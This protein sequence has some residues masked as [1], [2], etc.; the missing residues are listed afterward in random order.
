MDQ[1]SAAC[2]GTL[3][4]T[5]ASVEAGAARTKAKCPEC[6]RVAVIRQSDFPHKNS[7]DNDTNGE[8]GNEP[9]RSH[10]ASM[11]TAHLTTSRL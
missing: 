10:A 8:Q 9:P 2:P 7:K 5:Y 6:A 4:T 11:V 1:G 3:A